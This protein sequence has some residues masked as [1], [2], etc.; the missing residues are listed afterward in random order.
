MIP[1][2]MHHFAKGSTFQTC[3][4]GVYVLVGSAFMFVTD[5]FGNL[6]KV[7]VVKALSFVFSNYDHDIL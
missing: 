7:D 2:Y 1:R 3:F 5:D 6:Q 4:C